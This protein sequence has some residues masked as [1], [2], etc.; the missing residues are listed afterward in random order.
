[1]GGDSPRISMPGPQVD[2][3]ELERLRLQDEVWEEEVEEFLDRLNLAPGSRVLELNCAFGFDLPRLARRVGAGGE[4]VGV[5]PNPMVAQECKKL[6]KARGLQRIRV[7]LGDEALD[8]IP[9]GPYDAIFCSWKPGPRQPAPGTELRTLLRRAR[10]LISSSGRIA[11]FEF[12][13]E[14]I[15]MFP[16]SPALERL[17]A[18]LRESR[19]KEGWDTAAVCRLPGE[20]TAAGFMFESAWPRQKAEAPGSVTYRWIEQLLQERGRQLVE[21]KQLTEKEWAAFLQEW[22]QRRIDPKTLLFSPQAVGVLGRAIA[23]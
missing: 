11:V 3:Q 22:E 21:K 17:V 8:P 23:S 6:V 2:H 18:A 19:R 5:E 4:V 13:H 12:H 9:E 10:R 7:A 1:M 15:R 20:F 14:G 16:Y